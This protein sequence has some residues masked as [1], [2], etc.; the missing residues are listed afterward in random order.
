MQSKALA[1]IESPGNVY[2]NLSAPALVEHCVA[3]DEGILAI[4]G[5]LVTQTGKRTGRSPKDRF[6]VSH[7]ASKEKIDWGQTNQPIEPAVFDAL[8]DRIRQHLEGRDLF[9][10]DGVVGAD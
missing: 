5:A 8:F 9:V 3:R 2:R 1:G 6:F 7:G 10:V 4:S